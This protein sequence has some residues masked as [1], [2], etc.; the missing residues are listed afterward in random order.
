MKNGYDGFFGFGRKSSTDSL[1][2]LHVS[3]QLHH[4]SRSRVEEACLSFRYVETDVCCTFT[5]M[6]ILS[7]PDTSSSHNSAK[8]HNLLHPLHHSAHSIMVL[9]SRDS[10]ELVKFCSRQS[11]MGKQLDSSSSVARVEEQELVIQ[12]LEG[13]WPQALQHGS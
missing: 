8:T 11:C 1:D 9:R 4:V 5:P 12:W 13:T 6:L 7:H 10:A 3:R 2:E